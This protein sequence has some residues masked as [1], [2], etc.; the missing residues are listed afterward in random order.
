MLGP[1]IVSF[2][3]STLFWKYGSSKM[4]GRMSKVQS[5]QALKISSV[6]VLC[7]PRWTHTELDYKLIHPFM[8][9]LYLCC[10]FFGIAGTMT[11]PAG[12]FHGITSCNKSNLS[13]GQTHVS[14][15]DFQ[16]P[17]S[18]M[19]HTCKTSA[20]FELSKNSHPADLGQHD[21][22]LL[23]SPCRLTAAARALSRFL[24]SSCLRL[25]LVLA[26]PK[27]LPIMRAMRE[28]C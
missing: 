28:W 25:G 7:S 2:C 10:T 13:K 11:V 12:V 22:L 17:Q 23:M 27:W 8:F 20:A 5:W 19:E 14:S 18:S 15:Y 26:S 3:S 24:P 6:P 9:L 1:R 4:C 16:R 21:R